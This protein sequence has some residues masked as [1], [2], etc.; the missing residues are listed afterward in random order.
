MKASIQEKIALFI[1]HNDD[2]IVLAFKLVGIIIL[3]SLI[4]LMI[5]FG[6]FMVQGRNFCVNSFYRYWRCWKLFRFQPFSEC[7]ARWSGAYLLNPALTSC[8]RFTASLQV[9][10]C[11]HLQR[12]IQWQSKRLLRCRMTYFAKFVLRL[13]PQLQPRKQS[14]E[15][16]ENPKNKPQL[17]EKIDNVEPSP[18]F[19]CVPCGDLVFADRRPQISFSQR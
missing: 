2:N 4:V 19:Y 15:N 1:F 12:R 8:G 6:F 7:S 11:L 5:W 13:Q 18:A 10:L 17:L 9:F 14:L 3:F 16:N